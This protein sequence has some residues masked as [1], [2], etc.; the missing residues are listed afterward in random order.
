MRTCDL[1]ELIRNSL[2]DDWVGVNMSD[3]LGSLIT[4]S[5]QDLI[6]VISMLG[7]DEE[8]EKEEFNEQNPDEI[9]PGKWDGWWINIDNNLMDDEGNECFSFDKEDLEKYDFS[10]ILKQ[11]MNKE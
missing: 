6:D 3:Q 2:S 9:Y 8:A 4:I 10:N 7:E 1:V 11:N 5:K